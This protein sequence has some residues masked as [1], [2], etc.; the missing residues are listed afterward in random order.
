M[1]TGSHSFNKRLNTCSEPGTLLDTKNTD[2]VPSPRTLHPHR[3]K[4]ICQRLQKYNV[5]YSR[6][7]CRV[8]NKHGKPV[9]RERDSRMKHFKEDLEGKVY[10]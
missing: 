7:L 10:T 8:E 4:E 5:D 9:I 2:I 6:N 3:K 1:Y